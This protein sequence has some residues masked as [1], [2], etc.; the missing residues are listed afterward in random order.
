M[1]G[2]LSRNPVLLAVVIVVLAF[3]LAPLAVAVSIGFSSSPFLVFPPPGVSTRW[4][5]RFLGDPEF[6]AALRVSLVLATVVT[7]VGLFAALFIAF[8]LGQIDWP[9][10]R[11]WINALIL[12][13]L[14]VPVIL[15]AVGLLML[16][17]EMDLL[18]SPAG[19]AAAHLVIVVPLCVLTVQAAIDRL[20]PEI[21]SAAQSLGAGPLRVFTSVTL[22]QVWASIA[23]AGLLSFLFSFNDVTFAAFLGGPET[24]TLPLKMFGY[25]RYRLDPLVGAVS[26][27]FVFTTLALIVLADRLVG[28]DRI[29]GIRRDSE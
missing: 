14:L 11:S 7:F 24:Q 22:P 15:L 5:A 23:G 4:I 19:L 26:A 9:R 12:A 8:G 2:S 17:A 3:I 27:V 1:K 25:V 16:L 10:Q 28:F 20:N 6:L 13:P 29:L 18:G 21:A